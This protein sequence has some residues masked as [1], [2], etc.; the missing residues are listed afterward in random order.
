MKAPFNHKKEIVVPGVDS[1]VIRKYVSGILGGRTLD[2]TG[3]PNDNVLAGHV[4]IKKANGDYAPMPVSEKAYGTL[5]EG[6]SYVGVLY[7]TIPTDKPLASIMYDG[8]VNSELVPYPM[9][10]ILEAFKKACPHIVFEK[11]EEA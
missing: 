5:P 7:R 4:I 6:A 8:V 1:V 11:D 2:C 3:F 10:S 9:T